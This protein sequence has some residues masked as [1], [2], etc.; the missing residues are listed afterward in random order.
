MPFISHKSPRF[1]G[2]GFD[3][4]CE[5]KISVLIY[6]HVNS[7]FGIKAIFCY[8]PKVRKNQSQKIF[9]SEKISMSDKFNFCWHN[10]PWFSS[11]WEHAELKKFK[12]DLFTSFR[13]R[14]NSSLVRF[15]DDF[16]IHVWW[17]VFSIFNFSV[18]T[19]AE[20]REPIGKSSILLWLTLIC[21]T[22]KS[23]H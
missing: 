2:C 8:S 5:A 14:W 9:F 15:L 17:E 3:T 20:A 16:S 12:T 6:L 19:H 4:L 21:V 10:N 11:T 22:V 23:T 13:C 7:F 1:N 18:R